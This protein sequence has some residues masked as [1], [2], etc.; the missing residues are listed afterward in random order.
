MAAVN[1]AIS[2]M[3]T[4]MPEDLQSSAMDE[5]KPEHLGV[6]AGGLAF[7]DAAGGGALLGGFMGMMPED[8]LGGT[9]DAIADAGGEMEDVAGYLD[10]DDLANYF[11]YT[12][13]EPGGGGALGSIKEFVP[14]EI[15][16][17]AIDIMPDFDSLDDLE[18]EIVLPPEK[19]AEEFFE[20]PGGDEFFEQG[21]RPEEPR[22]EP[23]EGQIMPRPEEPK[24]D[25]GE[26]QMPPG[27]E[28]Q[29][30]GPG[31][32][33][34]PEEELPAPQPEPEE[35]IFAPV[36]E[37]EEPLNLPPP[38]EIATELPGFQDDFQEEFPATPVP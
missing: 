14:G 27:F 24:P 5:L 7:D 17:G 8:K 13:A 38:E 12:Q 9:L 19:P 16:D 6:V 33:P 15:V 32:I 18:Q 22:F 21:E 20:T 36:P 28:E 25:P 34:K 35:P 26:G 10:S 2:E 11:E 30:P 31:I 1:Q 23:G 4:F 37:P 3:W 29:R